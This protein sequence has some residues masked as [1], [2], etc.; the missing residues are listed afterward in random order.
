MDQ[1][2]LLRRGDA[3][4]V[5]TWNRWY[6][7]VALLLICFTLFRPGYWPNICVLRAF[8]IQV[9]RRIPWCRTFPRLQYALII[10]WTIPC[11]DV[12]PS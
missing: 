6:E 1:Q 7:T 5:L 8:F 4:L 3:T 9:A 2:G 10:A 11:E 12:G